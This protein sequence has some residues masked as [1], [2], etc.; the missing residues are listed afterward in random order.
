[1]FL[2]FCL[3]AAAVVRPASDADG[4]PGA[5][6][7]IVQIAQFMR[8]MCMHSIINN[9]TEYETGV[10]MLVSNHLDARPSRRIVRRP[11]FESFEHLERFPGERH[12]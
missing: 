7:E 11:S 10:S 6:A 12:K 2:V 4:P 3:Q 8:F 5:L 9:A 1:M